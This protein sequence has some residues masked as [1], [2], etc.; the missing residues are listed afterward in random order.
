MS[1]AQASPTPET[2]AVEANLRRRFIP[3]RGG[4]SMMSS[5]SS[6]SSMEDDP[7]FTNSGSN[8]RDNPY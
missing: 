5:G 7:G 8:Y 6:G 1:P 4:S 2:L 3:R